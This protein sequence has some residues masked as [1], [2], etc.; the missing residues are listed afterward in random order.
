MRE[1]GMGTETKTTRPLTDSAGVPRDKALPGKD[2]MNLAE[3]PIALLADRVPSG[4]KAVEY[5]D[6]IF[7]E[8]SGRTIDRKLTISAS[9]AYGLPTAIDDDVILALIQLTKTANG[10]SYREVEFGRLD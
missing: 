1:P 10:F 7:D 4:Q 6:Q 2:E 8:K 9:E 5:R 3:F